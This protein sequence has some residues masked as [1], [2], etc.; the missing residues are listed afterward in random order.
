MLLTYNGYSQEML[1]IL[2]CTGQP[3]QQRIIQ[4]KIS[5]VQRSPGLEESNGRVIETRMGRKAK[6]VRL[7]L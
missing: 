6:M 4:C 2:K 3:P 7:P 1:N 5:I